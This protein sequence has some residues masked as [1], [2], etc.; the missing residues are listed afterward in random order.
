MNRYPDLLDILTLCRLILEISGGK[1]NKKKVT[2]PMAGRVALWVSALFD[3]VPM[4]LTHV[5]TI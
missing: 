5:N 1:K 2:A 3:S 4:M